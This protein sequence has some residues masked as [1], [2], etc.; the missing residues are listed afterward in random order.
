MFASNE[1]RCSDSPSKKKGQMP[2]LKKKKE[3]CYAM[4]SAIYVDMK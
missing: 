2:H 4:K 1:G 3:R